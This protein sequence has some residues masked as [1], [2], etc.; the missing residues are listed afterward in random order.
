VKKKRRKKLVKAGTQFGAL[1]KAAGF[2]DYADYLN[3]PHWR[4]LRTNALGDNACCMCSGREELQVHHRSYRR[5]GRE[6]ESDLMVLCRVCHNRVHRW[7]DAKYPQRSVCFKSERTDQAIAALSKIPRRERTP[8]QPKSQ[9]AIGKRKRHELS[10][11]AFMQKSR[12]AVRR[13]KKQIQRDRVADSHARLVASLGPGEETI[14]RLPTFEQRVRARIAQR[15]ALAAREEQRPHDIPAPNAGDGR[16]ADTDAKHP[17]T[18]GTL[19]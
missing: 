3:S 19:T 18:V 17:A 9:P 12:K 13:L 11:A 6:N 4:A 10:H 8:K 1:L 14:M 2:D 16:P 7:L 5:L 15:Q